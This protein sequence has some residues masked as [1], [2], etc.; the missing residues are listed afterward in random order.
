MESRFITSNNSKNPKEIG[1]I[2]YNKGNFRTAIRYFKEALRYDP[3]DEYLYYKIGKL[4]TEINKNYELGIK[5]FHKAISVNPKKTVYWQAKGMNLFLL[6]RGPEAEVCFKECSKLINHERKL[7]LDAKSLMYSNNHEGALKCF[8]ELIEVNPDETDAYVGKGECLLNLNQ[9]AKARNLFK[10]ALRRI[11]LS[12]NKYNYKKG[13]C[14]FYLGQYEDALNCFNEVIM[15]EPKNYSALSHRARL[16]GRLRRTEEAIEAHHK[17]LEIENKDNDIQLLRIKGISFHI[18]GMTQQA[19]QAYDKIL[20]LYPNDSYVLNKKGTF[21]D[22]LGRYN[23]AIECFD[24]VLKL[25]PKNIVCLC[26]KA[27]SYLIVKH[28][29]E[30]QL[31]LRQERQFSNVDLRILV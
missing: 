19:I 13:K 30:Y 14:L 5:Y 7:R 20:L 23:E 9:F 22:Y 4:E 2:E 1:E 28:L 10:E 12:P 11:N 31:T 16:L 26:K 27:Y 15:S 18:L 21:L 24:R 17:I 29:F 3:N 6:N 25:N 8:N